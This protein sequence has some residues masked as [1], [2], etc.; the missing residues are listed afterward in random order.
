MIRHD[1]GHGDFG[2]IVNRQV[3]T[4]RLDRFADNRSRPNPPE[5][6]FPLR[7][8]VNSYQHFIKHIPLTRGTMTYPTVTPRPTSTRSM[9]VNRVNRL[10]RITFLAL[11]GIL[12]PHSVQAEFVGEVHGFWRCATMVDIHL[13]GGGG[14][15]I[16]PS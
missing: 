13:K 7:Q 15:G 4:L 11:A 14:L 9:C 16:I 1:Q 2:F 8:S 5:I 6:Q 10:F 3:R 12:M